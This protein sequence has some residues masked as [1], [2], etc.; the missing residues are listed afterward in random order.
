[1]VRMVLVL[2][3]MMLV[4]LVE[5]WKFPK[6]LVGIHMM[7]VI[8][9]HIQLVHAHTAEDHLCVADHIF[10]VGISTHFQFESTAIV[11]TT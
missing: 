1:M 11:V 9:L 4:L 10:R 6:V 7:L 2:M 5:G 8:E 3:V